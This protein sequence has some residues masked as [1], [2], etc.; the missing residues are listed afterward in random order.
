MNLSKNR[1]HD[2]L[3]KFQVLK[4]NFFKEFFWNTENLKIVEYVMSSLFVMVIA[5]DISK[6]HSKFIKFNALVNKD[7]RTERFCFISFFLLKKNLNKFHVALS[8]SYANNLCIHP[9]SLFAFDL[10]FYFFFMLGLHYISLYMGIF[11]MCAFL[12]LHRHLKRLRRWRLWVRF[13][14]VL[15]K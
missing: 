9:L 12:G 5:L 15:I 1:T 10:L 14:G 13:R 3:D 7:K 11:T 8:L 6:K 2:I 4:T